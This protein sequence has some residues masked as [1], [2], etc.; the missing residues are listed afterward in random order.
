MSVHIAWFCVNTFSIAKLLN[1]AMLDIFQ[2][3]KICFF[4]QNLESRL[5][6]RLPVD[7][8]RASFTYN[9]IR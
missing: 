6:S 9:L 5:I 2:Y 3:N 4:L 7:T 1:K 8:S